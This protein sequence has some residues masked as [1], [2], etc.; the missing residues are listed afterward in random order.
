MRVAFRIRQ[1]FRSRCRQLRFD[2]LPGRRGGGACW[3]SDRHLV[4][5]STIVLTEGR[6][7]HLK[8]PLGPYLDGFL[9]LRREQGFAAES[10]AANLEWVTCFGEY[11]L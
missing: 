3:L 6:Q 7:R 2:L 10:I 11:L 1:S 4:M 5:V 8:T 9:S